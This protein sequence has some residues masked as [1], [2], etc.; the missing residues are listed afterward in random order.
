MAVTGGPDMRHGPDTRHGRMA[1]IGAPH[2]GAL[3]AG[4]GAAG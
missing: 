3:A 2:F 4:F 1:V